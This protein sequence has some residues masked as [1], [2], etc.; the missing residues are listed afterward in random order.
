MYLVCLSVTTYG[1]IPYKIFSVYQHYAR[2]KQS[3][4]LD[5]ITS[6]FHI[7]DLTI[8]ED[9]SMSNQPRSQFFPRQISPLLASAS[10]TRCGEI[11]PL[12]QNLKVFG[13]F[14][15]VYLVFGKM[16]NLLWD[17]CHAFGKVALL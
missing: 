8:T 15:R 9:L 11:S 1:P 17:I 12:W 6:I 14:L 7:R 5:K 3:H 4:W 10:V 2:F 16:L 13:P